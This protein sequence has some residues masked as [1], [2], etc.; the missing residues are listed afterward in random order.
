MI[1]LARQFPWLFRGP[2]LYTELPREVLARLAELAF[3]DSSVRCEPERTQRTQRNCFTSASSAVQTESKLLFGGHACKRCSAGVP[4]P[5]QF[6]RA[7]PRCLSRSGPGNGLSGETQIL[8]GL[9]RPR[10]GHDLL[11]RC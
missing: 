10:L 5:K 3:G 7:R 4:F 6:V 8:T 1:S 11:E 2:L 9:R